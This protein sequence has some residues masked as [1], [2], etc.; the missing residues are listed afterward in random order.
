MDVPTPVVVREAEPGERHEAG[1]V[2][3]EAYSQYASGDGDPAWEA[4]LDEIADVA[5]RAGRTT[6]LVALD[7][8]RIVGSATLELTDRVEPDDDPPLQPDEAHIRM[9][10]VHP[11]VRRRGIARA[12]MRACFDRSRAAGKTVM[13]LHT[14]PRMREAQVMYEAM[15]FERLEDRVLPDGFV[16]LTYRCAID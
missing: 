3:A 14:T 16:L 6:V 2:T 4:Y 5:G 9:L 13:T 15:G 7:G 1:R 8:D 10:G 11:K 12:L